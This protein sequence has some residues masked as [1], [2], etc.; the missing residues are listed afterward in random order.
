MKKLEN[1]GR[2]A[3]C[4]VAL[5]LI[6]FASEAQVGIGTVLPQ[7]K[8]HVNEGSILATTTAPDPAINP[9]YDPSDPLTVYYR[10]RWYHDKSAFRVLGGIITNDGFDS[11]QVGLFSIASGYESVASGIGSAAFGART[12]AGGSW[13]FASGSNTYATGLMSFAH[14]SGISATGD[15]SV[16]MGSAVSTNGKQ[17]S[18][19]FG[20][21]AGGNLTNDAN[22]QMVMRFSGGYKLFSNPLSTIG[23]SLS[24]GANAWAVMSDVNKKENFIPVNG[25]DFLKKIAALRLTSWNYKGQDPKTFRHYGPMAQDFF[26]A[27]GKDSLGT[28]GTDTTINQAD[29][30]GVN[31]IAIQALVK[32]TDSL[33]QTH[34]ELTIEL[35]NIKA[36]LAFS[37]FAADRKKKKR[38]LLS[39]R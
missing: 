24:P 20:D 26:R 29:F 21:H 31:L 6:A 2:I 16:A 19:I 1:V 4:A 30:D 28:I 22:H 15:Y 18:F 38:A 5:N 9:F 11:Q 13:S 7:A 36:Q 25:E 27:F 37:D 12:T 8:L 34:K 32:R 39:K 14:G 17:G 33:L 23:V 35:S 3:F 10:M